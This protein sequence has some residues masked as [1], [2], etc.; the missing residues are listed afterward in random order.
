MSYV[1][2]ENRIDR[3]ALLQGAG[4]VIADDMTRP[5][6]HTA[7]LPQQAFDMTKG[8]ARLT[9]GAV[10]QNMSVLFLP[11]FKGAKKLQE[12][13]CMPLTKAR[14]GQIPSQRIVALAL[15]LARSI[16]NC[17][18]RDSG[19]EEMPRRPMKQALFRKKFRDLENRDAS[20][21]ATSDELAAWLAQH[22]AKL[23]PADVDFLIAVG[24][25]LY[26]AEV[27]RR[28]RDAW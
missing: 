3:A 20:A 21:T 18:D 8:F 6:A 4:N 22:A 19:R 27:E 10:D 7:A 15:A 1:L 17:L 2:F 14:T 12:N 25:T 26:S 24:R 28:W 5:H 11:L 9:V 16:W 13:K 23:E